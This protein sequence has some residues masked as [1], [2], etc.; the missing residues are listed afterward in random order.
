M[1]KSFSAS[2][3]EELNSS[4]KEQRSMLDEVSEGD[5]SAFEVKL[6]EQRKKLLLCYRKTKQ[7]VVKIKEFLSID[8]MLQEVRYANMLSVSQ[9]NSIISIDRSI[10]DTMLN[11]S[12]RLDKEG[13][14]NKQ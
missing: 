11:D 8:T 1:S 13:N 3:Y 7:G 10:G 5:H 6:Q 12:E 9:S 2:S 14:V 4:S